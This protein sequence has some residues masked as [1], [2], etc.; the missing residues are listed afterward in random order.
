MIWLLCFVWASAAEP[1]DVADIETKIA[2]ERP[3]ELVLLTADIGVMEQAFPEH[4]ALKWEKAV[5]SS[6][7]G[8][9]FKV[10]YKAALMR[11]RLSATVSQVTPDMVEWEHHGR[12][13]FFTRWSVDET[14][15]APAIHVKTWMNPP[16]WPL[17]RYYMKR[18]KPA[19]EACYMEAL[20]GLIRIRG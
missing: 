7:L 5:Q 3:A 8:A 15:V 1:E 17:K 12:K 20:N 19:W 2:V 6:G 16:P 13:G 9:R 18:I 4:C 11:R 14:G 10:T